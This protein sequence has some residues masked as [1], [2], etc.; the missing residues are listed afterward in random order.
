MENE[1][2]PM[3]ICF[4]MED[5]KD[6]GSIELKIHLRKQSIIAIMEI[7]RDDPVF[8][9]TGDEVVYYFKEWRIHAGLS[10]QVASA[11]FGMTR[12]RFLKFESNG[13]LGSHYRDDFLKLVARTYGC[14]DL[15]KPP[16]DL[17]AQEKEAQLAA[18]LK[19]LGLD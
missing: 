12:K 14:D 18:E 16:P 15:T 8:R 5:N 7:I 10:E 9:Q 4:D 11:E 17:I 19:E 6:A 13:A 1:N 3:N 2:A